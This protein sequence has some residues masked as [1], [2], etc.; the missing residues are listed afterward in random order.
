GGEDYRVNFSWEMPFTLASVP[1]LLRGGTDTGGEGVWA[2]VYSI[3]CIMSSRLTKRWNRAAPIWPRIS[4]KVI[5]AR[6]EWNSP[7]LAA[8]GI[9][10][11]RATS[12]MPK[13]F[14]P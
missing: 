1:L 4:N 12:C 8:Q 6:G 14:R 2:R 3:R 7:R 9:S 13:N 5:Q 10:G 11:P